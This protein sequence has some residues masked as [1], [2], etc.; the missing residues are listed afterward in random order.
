MWIGEVAVIN[1]LAV[2]LEQAGLTQNEEASNRL[3]ANLVK[4][5]MLRARI[6]LRLNPKGHAEMIRAMNR[7]RI[8][9]KESIPE[10]EAAMGAVVEVSQRLL[11]AEWTRVRTGEPAFARTKRAAGLIIVAAILSIAGGIVLAWRTASS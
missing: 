6:E 10:L 9:V 5:R 4:I 3:H 7:V 8:A 2:R 11:K 1:E